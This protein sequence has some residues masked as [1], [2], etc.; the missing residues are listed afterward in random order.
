MISYIYIPMRLLYIFLSLILQ[1]AHLN[2]FNNS[3]LTVPLIQRTIIL[4][5]VNTSKKLLPNL[6]F[7]GE[8]PRTV[9]QNRFLCNILSRLPHLKWFSIIPDFLF[10]IPHKPPTNRIKNTLSTKTLKKKTFSTV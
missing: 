10:T 5:G 2:Y 7:I 3:N 6:T 1:Y 4:K 8:H 9:L